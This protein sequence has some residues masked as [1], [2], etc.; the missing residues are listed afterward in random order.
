MSHYSY[1]AEH[2]SAQTAPATAFYHPPPINPEFREGA[3]VDYAVP[4]S[5]EDST[6]QHNTQVD[7]AALV[8][9]FSGLMK[10]VAKKTREFDDKHQISS[11]S[12]ET[13][14]KIG[15]NAIREAKRIDEKHHVVD[16]SKLAAK[17][18][19]EKAKDVNEKHNVVDKTKLAAKMTME[20]AKDVNE[21]H[22]VTQK[23]AKAASLTSKK[24]LAGAKFVSSRVLSKEKNYSAETSS[25][26]A[27][28]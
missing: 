8:A 19:I 13:S 7:G 10:T 17:M 14:K 18:A 6:E 27:A 28:H 9:G 23:T 4:S 11:R 12:L 5:N 22:H 1:N 3:G 21:K 15:N 24:M 16:K 20:K 25:S 2:N 26:A